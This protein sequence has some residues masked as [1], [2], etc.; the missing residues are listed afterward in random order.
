MIAVINRLDA[1]MNGRNHALFF[2]R[3][4]V[5]AMRQEF[6]I[7]IKCAHSFAVFSR[8]WEILGLIYSMAEEQPHRRQDD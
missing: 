6:L 5:A 4:Q 8:V 3:S 1:H 7:T 2:K